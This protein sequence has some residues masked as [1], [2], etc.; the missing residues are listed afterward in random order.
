M[1]AKEN[2]HKQGAGT[3][4]R[5]NSSNGGEMEAESS[6]G[7][8]SSQF[9]YQQVSTT[10]HASGSVTPALVSPGFP[11]INIGNFEF[12]LTRLKEADSVM[13]GPFLT[14]PHEMQVK[15]K[16]SDR[17]ITLI[18]CLSDTV[19]LLWHFRLIGQSSTQI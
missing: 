6:T 3:V 12:S 16:Q 15:P 9:G 1:R 13:L 2:R 5:S 18:D 4:S 19:L 8:S 14:N 7:A 17:L 10:T 11:G